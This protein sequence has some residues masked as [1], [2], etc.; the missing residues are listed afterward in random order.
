MM[1]LL[2]LQSKVNIL[3][4]LMYLI[5]SII[6]N[7]KDS[8]YA[9]LFSQNIVNNFCYVFEKVSIM[10]GSGIYIPSIMSIMLAEIFKFFVMCKFSINLF[11]RYV[12]YVYW[13]IIF[14]FFEISKFSGKSTF[15]NFFNWWLLAVITWRL[16]HGIMSI[17][18]G[19]VMI[20]VRIRSLSEQWYFNWKYMYMYCYQM[21]ININAW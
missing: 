5:D 17:M 21:F 8:D 3:L 20:G 4:P 15:G 19:Q 7:V 18:L 14:F 11:G 6:K 1:L 2:C 10:T 13:S 16:H 9:Q 12:L